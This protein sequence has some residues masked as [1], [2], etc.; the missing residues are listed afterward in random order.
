MLSV[1]HMLL[2]G[3]AAPDANA[4]SIACALIRRLIEEPV[5]V[6]RVDAGTPPESDMDSD[7][8]LAAGARE[9]INVP[10][11][12]ET[13]REDL[14]AALSRLPANVR[15]L[16][17]SPWIREV[18]TP[19]AFLAA[20]SGDTLP[21]STSQTVRVDR[22]VRWNGRGL[23]LARED[24]GFS[25]GRWTLRQDATAVVLAGGGSARMGR[26]KALL[27]ARDGRPLI[28][29][30]IEGLAPY[31]REI[32]ISTNAPESFAFL[33]C[34]MVQ[35]TTTG[36]GPMEGIASSLTAAS[37]DRVF[38]I[39]CDVPDPDIDLMMTLLREAR[40]RD[41]AVPMTPSDHLEPVFAVYSKAILPRL[42]AALDHGEKRIIR[43]FDE[44]AMAFPRLPSEDHIRSFNHPAEYE[45]WFRQGDPVA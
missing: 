4:T 43:A 2:V 10:S 39:A 16:C 32:L 30:T 9:V 44:H 42:R 26:C 35:D 17:P 5:T 14:A 19:G 20:C 34:P 24:L 36:R 27:S 13:L 18:V 33:G 25:R 28:Q 23:D 41:G 37:M 22:L 45:A 15:L 3:P 8:L 12:P 6:L 38:V 11:T 1:P 40:G 29:H 7:R 21:P 31:F